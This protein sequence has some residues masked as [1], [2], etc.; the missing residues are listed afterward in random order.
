M[1]LEEIGSSPPQWQQQ[2][3]DLTRLCQEQRDAPLLWAVEV[4]KCLQ[5]ADVAMPSVELGQLLI[6]HLCWSNNG[7]MLWKYIEQAMGTQIVHSLHVLALLTSSTQS[8]G[9]QDSL[10]YGTNNQNCPW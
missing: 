10:R 3:L 6:S 9:L 5:V 1:G 7:P 8:S 2:V 4:G